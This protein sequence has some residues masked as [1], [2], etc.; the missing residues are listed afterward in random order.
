MSSNPSESNAPETSTHSTQPGGEAPAAEA[1]ASGVPAASAGPNLKN[2][3]PIKKPE[4]IRA[5]GGPEGPGGDRPRFGQGRPG[6]GERRDRGPR[7]GPTP[8][9]KA[10][11]MSGTLNS[12]RD[13]A[14]KDGMSDEL[15]AEIEAMLAASA[16]EE[17]AKRDAKPSIKP[18]APA[19]V[20]GPR[21]VQSGREHRRGKVVSV[22]PTDI[23]LEFGPKELGV[24]QRMQYKEEELP[25]TGEEIEVVVDRFETAES[26][27][28]CSKPG[29]VQKAAWEMLEVGQVVE[30]RVTGTNKG[31]LDLEVAGHR[32][33]MPAGQA[34]LDRIPDL[35]VMV[36][37]KLTCTV[38]QVDRRGAGNIVLSRRDLLKAEREEKA[39]KLKGELKEGQQIEGTVRKIMPFGAFIDLGGLDG[40]CHISD[41]TY[42]RV[43]PTEKN[44]QKYVQEGAHVKVV[45]LKLDID[46]NRISL[47]MKQLAEDPY[48]V[49]VKDLVEG[50]ET[51][52]RV[53]RFTE[54]GAF[55]N[56]AP[57]VDGLVHISEISHK[58]I[59]KPE[60]VLKLEEVVAVK[61]VK[62]DPGSRKISLSIKA[63][64]QR[65]APAP[66]SREA[67]MAEKRAAKDKMAEE[68][69][70]EINKET[71]ELR[72]QREQ[73]RGKQLTGGFGKDK[74]V[75]KFM[76]QGLGDI[77]L[78]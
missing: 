57:G 4:V 50:S 66:G 75:S 5:E 30:A 44:V 67:M 21:V 8:N 62:I 35:S 52:G 9:E 2:L 58:R 51:T 74:K 65:E 46:S 15:N 70:K 39:K 17:A 76:G 22:G 24:V 38:T 10:P 31:G 1:S 55:I 6:G 42:D 23:F 7:K 47:G 59:G 49:A 56:L 36:G 53:V 18:M 77:K 27:F 64:K 3:P 78:G 72:R 19:A 28:I 16:E 73:F 33:F 60:E 63:M 11:D 34:S 20:R 69:L 25:K 61:V 14:K 41:M 12:V 40:L 29:S 43:T 26:L 71:P 48:A 45:I 68:R 32:A 37:E 54:F 13:E